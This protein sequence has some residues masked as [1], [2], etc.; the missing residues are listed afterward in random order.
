MLP[1]NATSNEKKICPTIM[2]F[3]QPAL[4]QTKTA[5]KPYTKIPTNE[6][7]AELTMQPNTWP[8]LNAIVGHY[9]LSGLKL[10]HYSIL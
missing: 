7:V 2:V 8:V 5:A 6:P 1:I 9:P 4:Q 10:F 3:S